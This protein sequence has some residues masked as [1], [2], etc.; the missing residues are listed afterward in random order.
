[1]SIYLIDD[2]EVSNFLFEGIL[3]KV[4]PAIGIRIFLSGPEAL[5]ELGS[6]DQDGYPYIVFLDLSMPLMDGWEFLK[7]LGQRHPRLNSR[8]YIL[9]S[10]IR[11]SDEDK[12]KGFPLVTGFLQKPLTQ[13]GIMSILATSLLKE[14]ST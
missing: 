2:D 4:A 13:E 14:S 7:E 3:S 10:S 1:M 11:A 5:E 6:G 8:V 12:S 9:T